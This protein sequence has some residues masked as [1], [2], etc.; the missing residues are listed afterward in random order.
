[1]ILEEAEKGLKFG[2]I[3]VSMSPGLPM[4]AKEAGVRGV[5]KACQILLCGNASMKKLPAEVPGGSWDKY[6]FVHQGPLPLSL[7]RVSL[8]PPAVKT[9]RDNGTCRTVC[10]E[11]AQLGIPPSLLRWLGEERCESLPWQ[12]PHD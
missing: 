10:L 8:L 12:W 11:V 5:H 6:R 3:K 2:T 4:L 1:M 7:W 9:G